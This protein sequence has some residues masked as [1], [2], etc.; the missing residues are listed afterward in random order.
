MAIFVTPRSEIAQAVAAIWGLQLGNQTMTDVLAMVSAP[1]GSVG[2]VIAGAFDASYGSASDAAVAAAFVSNLG[3]T[4]DAGFSADAVAGAAAYVEG[5]LAAGSSRAGTLMAIAKAFGN[6]PATGDADVDAAIAAFNSKVA[7]AVTH[8]STAGTTDGTIDDVPAATSFELTEGRDVLTGTA[9][10]DVF[11]AWVFDNQN[12]FQSGDVINGGGGTDT[13]EI[14]L[15]WSSD[16][17][18]LALTQGVENIFIRSQSNNNIGNNGDNNPA[19]DPVADGSNDDNTVDAELMRGVQQWWNTDSRADLV[20]EDVRILDNEI[21]KDIAIGW[22]NADPS[23]VESGGE[24]KVD[25]EVYFS[26]E[27]L[28]K[29]GDTTNNAIQLTVGNQIE[30]QFFDDDAP[31]KD[32]PYTAV[33]FV[34]NGVDVALPLDLTQVDTYDELWD[35]FN[36]AFDAAKDAGDFDGALDGV[37]VSRIEDGNTFFSR[38]GQLRSADVIQL[39]A[40]AGTIAPHPT[41]GWLADS[42]LPS[43]N[44]FSARVTQGAAV[45]ISDLITSTI[46]LDNVG[47]ESESGDLVIGSMSTRT[48]VERFDIEVVNNDGTSGAYTSSGSWIGSAS[49]TNNFLREVL[50]HNGAD[51]IDEPDYLY[52]GTGMDDDNNNLTTI[53]QTFLSTQSTAEGFVKYQKAVDMAL[54]DA[55]G[56]HDVRVFDASEMVG[57][58]KL[59]AYIS[60]SAIQ[61]YQDLVDTRAD[62]GFEDVDFNYDLGSANDSLNLVLDEGLWDNG[63]SNSSVVP[64]R[65]DFHFNVDGNAGNDHIQVTI[66]GEDQDGPF[67]G[68]EDWYNNQAINANITVNGGSGDDTIRTPGAGDMFINGDSGND[69]IY[70]DNTGGE[71]DW[72]NQEKAAWVF[73][74]VDNDV[75]DLESETPASISA[76]NARLTVDFRGY[77]KQVDIGT[78]MD[79]TSNVTITDLTINQAIK[80]AI[81]D[82]AVLS[83]L[84]VAED[85]PGRT[86]IVRSLIDGERDEQDLSVT[87][88]AKALT[89]T[90]AAITGL[91]LFSPTSGATSMVNLLNGYTVSDFVTDGI[92]I[93]GED[94]TATSDNTIEGGTGNDVIV[95][96]TAGYLV[97]SQDTLYG[98]NDTIVYTGFGNG[99]DTIVNFDTTYDGFAETYVGTGQAR[100]LLEL[101]FT[102]SDGSPAAQ[103]IIFDGTTVTLSAPA[104][105][106]V[107][108]AEDV[109]Y[110]FFVQMENST[111]WNVISW[112]GINTVV[113]ERVRFGDVDDA[114]AGDFT[115]TYTAASGGNGTITPT[116][117]VQGDPGTALG[118]VSEFTVTFSVSGTAAAA[119]GSFTF[120]GNTINY[121]QGDGAVTLQNTILTNFVGTDWAITDSD[122]DGNDASITFTAIAN[123]ATALG[124]TADFD[125]GTNTI[126]GT[127][128]GTVGEDDVDGFY[129]TVQFDGPG[130]GFDFLD[131]SAYDPAGVVVNGVTLI[132]VAGDGFTIGSAAPS[133]QQYSYVR[134]TES[135]TNE[136][137]YTIDLVTVD[138]VATTA[139]VVQL[140]GTADFGD[141]AEVNFVAD[142]FIV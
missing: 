108:P 60:S 52:I 41:L 99:A 126:V 121:A 33:Q 112:D 4:T 120:D 1:G 107:I 86:L 57:Q 5:E 105:Q 66:G 8:S 55:D 49:S 124:T 116:V 17:A 141:T 63:N 59:G 46:Y 9:G 47:R 32:L 125:L 23:S 42:G 122:L 11:R 80:A 62:D 139:D 58:V 84:L 91:T 22:A 12:T 21:T 79:A 81:N 97:A 25:Y 26:P 142:N 103:T 61:K 51:G 140:I 130:R 24:D 96:G 138:S 73:N 102:D 34:V 93:N 136:G 2:A 75:F 37:T 101:V 88:S 104:N 113:L 38:D 71:D 30:T 67:G 76:V 13:L 74:A 45:T 129:Q 137:F 131:Y 20:I 100:E 39:S 133:G 89:T 118:S 70:T 43:D 14:T 94:A 111:L 119:A 64:G 83:K 78:S 92:T 134:M 56:L 110:Q 18:I 3:I 115:G 98:S 10:D 135:T 31:L 82:D 127:I 27:S 117:L 123:G 68:D 19:A 36:E 109:S 7:G 28:R 40:E 48:G 106:G 54:L 72:Y 29:Q 35:A 69:T 15:G 50:A 77:T 128:S 90:Q 16:F 95:L 53:R 85:G 87:F 114:V 132:D 44:A 65:H 6:L